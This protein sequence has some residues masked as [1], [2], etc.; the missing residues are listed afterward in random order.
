MS[1][2]KVILLLLIGFPARVTA[3][4]S[5]PLRWDFTLPEDDGSKAKAAVEGLLKNSDYD[6]LVCLPKLWDRHLSPAARQRILTSLIGKLG[7]QTPLK[8]TNFGPLEIMGRPGM[9]PREHGTSLKHDI[10]TE[11]G[12]SAWA[13]EKMLRCTLPVFNEHLDFGE[14]SVV[15]RIRMAR[16]VVMR[17]LRLPASGDRVVCDPLRAEEQG[18]EALNRLIG[19]PSYRNISRMPLWWEKE[20]SEPSR[21]ELL[22]QLF[23]RLEST[24]AVRLVDEGDMFVFSR[25]LAGIPAFGD[26][27]TLL[28]QDEWH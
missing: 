1:L 26:E 24:R 17:S 6:L 2:K 5:H 19:E 15:Q 14:G 10:L 27:K 9:P 28:E 11:S 8:L 4:E 22:V 7:S 3:Q 23:D 25:H 20:L 16:R 18:L 13:I 21:K 12:R